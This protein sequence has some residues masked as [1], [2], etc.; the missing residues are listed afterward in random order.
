MSPP[1]L[2]LRFDYLTRELLLTLLAFSPTLPPL[3]VLTNGFA[4]V[5][6]VFFFSV[7]TDRGP[8]LKPTRFSTLTSFRAC[9]GPLQVI[10]RHFIFSFTIFFPEPSQS[11][12]FR[13]L[14]LLFF[15]STILVLASVLDDPDF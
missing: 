6:M 1:T 15:K 4:A 13:R 12:F 2:G 9:A 3:P 11:G 5:T 14:F 10:F 8:P 7:N